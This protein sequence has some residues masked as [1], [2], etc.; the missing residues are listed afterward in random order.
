M[1][2]IKRTYME[3]YPPSA[4]FA[5]LKS[6]NCLD[7]FLIEE[8]GMVM[9]QEIS[10]S[11]KLEWKKKNYPDGPTTILKEVDHYAY[12]VPFLRNLQAL[13]QNEAVRRS[14][15]HPPEHKNGFLRTVLDGDYS[16]ENE[17]FRNNRESLG[18]NLYYDDLGIANPLGTSSKDQKLAIFY[19]TLVNIEPELRSSQ[20]AIQLLAIVKTTYMKEEGA[21]QK[22]LAP[23]I[24]DIIKLQTEGTNIVINGQLKNYKGSLLFFSGDTLA[25]ALIGGFKESVSAHRPCR[26]CMTTIDE[27]KNSFRESDFV[28]R[29]TRDHD[30]H[31]ATVTEGH[32]TKQAQEY[33]KKYYGVNSKSPLLKIPFFDV[34]TCL[35]QDCMHV[36]IEG[37]LE[38]ASRCFLKYSLTEQSIFTVN[39]INKALDRFDFGHFHRDKPAKIQR[40]N[41]SDNGTLRQT[42]AQMFTLAHTLPF[43]IADW[44]LSSD[45]SNLNAQIDCHILLLQIMNLCFSYEIAI[46]SLATLSRMIEI[47]AM[48]FDRL[49]PGCLIPKFH[50]L[51]HVPRFIKLFG[52]A[53]QHWCFRFES[54]HAYIKSLVPVVRN[55]KN[56]PYTLAYRY[57]ARMSS[58]LMSSPNQSSRTF[59]YEGDTIASGPRVL[60][61]ALSYARLFHGLVDENELNACQ[62]MLSP[63]LIIHGTVYQRNTI[64]LF[65]YDEDALPTF[66]EVIDIVIL[67]DKKF[68]IVSLL[69]TTCYEPKLNAY[70]IEN[71]RECQQRIVDIRNL[72]FP[73]ALSSF[74][75]ALAK[76]VPLINHEHVEF[77]G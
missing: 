19:W 63:K 37:V 50:F 17:F 30:E 61:Q 69:E 46:E 29:N 31:I 28:L 36:L 51:I 41:F 57:Q 55:F 65:Q 75:I 56:M 71:F 62:I 77:I 14:I 67:Q 3:K 47:F 45:D 35:P 53:R 54:V 13:L 16:K 7:K 40:E 18:I 10:I 60:L 22:I 24:D 74:K 76:F 2:V 11:T 26:T 15:D 6:K 48:R 27:W 4:L 38:K 43:F 73:H 72:L 58:R 52:P 1:S 25:S 32:T 39:D 12:V 68:L 70:R 42:A 9:P 44:T 33:W 34:T 21:L 59:L 66:A 49:Y 23:F 8:M 64:I 20:N 5:S